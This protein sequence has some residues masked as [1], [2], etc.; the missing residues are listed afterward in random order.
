LLLKK[1]CFNR[2]PPRPPCRSSRVVAPPMDDTG[3]TLA[4]S[5]RTGGV[6]LVGLQVGHRSGF[7]AHVRQHGGEES[8][9]SGRKHDNAMYVG[10]VFPLDGSSWISPTS[11]TPGHIFGWKPRSC[12]PRFHDSVDPRRFP[13]EGVVLKMFIPCVRSWGWTCTSSRLKA[14]DAGFHVV[15]CAA[16]TMLM[17]DG[18]VATMTLVV[19]SCS[20]VSDDLCVGL[21]LLW[22]QSSGCG[23]TCGDDALW[24]AVRSWCYSSAR[25][26]HIS[27][28][29]LFARIGAASL[30]CEKSFV[31]HRPTRASWG[32]CGKVFLGGRSSVKSESLARGGVMTMTPAGN[33]GDDAC[34]HRGVCGLCLVAK[35]LCVPSRRSCSMMVVKFVSVF[36]R[37]PAN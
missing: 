21:P 2:T 12:D 37:F 3:E 24:R 19:G 11:S 14:G 29:K 9:C 35:W 31:W 25:V 33:L 13:P 23:W 16:T 32:C 6:R 18:L 1:I 7:P 30:L 4:A 17:S 28:S 20:G 36:D 10:A 34:L 8:G 26:L 22:S 27:S 15:A 5:S